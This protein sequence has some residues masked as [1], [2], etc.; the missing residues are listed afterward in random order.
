MEIEKRD[1]IQSLVNFIT[2]ETR[3]PCNV[4][5]DGMLAV[6]K[7]GGN[8]VF[9]SSSFNA[10]LQVNSVEAFLGGMAYGIQNK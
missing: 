4:E 10:N 7:H 2:S 9:T 8:I 1:S 5:F 3:R 6:V